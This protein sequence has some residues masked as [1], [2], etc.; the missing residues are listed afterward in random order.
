[1]SGFLQ[2]IWTGRANRRYL[3]IGFAVS[4]LFWILF[5]LLYPNTFMVIDS[6][7]YV[8]AAFEND[9]VHVWPIGYSKF[10][11]VIGLVSH[12][13]NLVAVSQYC[14]LQTTLLVFYFAM[15]YLFQLGKIA[16]AALYVFVLLN[17]IYL[18]TSNF[19]MSDSLFMSISL[20]WL[21]NLLWIIYRPKPWMLLTQAVLLLLAFTIRQVAVI[22]PVIA[23][24][25][26]LF[27][28]QRSRLKVIGIALSCLPVAGFVI[29]SIHMNETRYGSEMFSP[30]QGW[31]AANNALY[32]YDHVP[33]LDKEPVPPRF[34]ELDNLVR[35]YC[36][37][38]HLPS[39]VRAST[40]ALGSFYIF[41]YPSPLLVYQYEKFGASSIVIN[42]NNFAK[43]GPLY[44]DYGSF[45]LR[46]YPF[47]Y[48]QYYVVPN[49]SLYIYPFPEVYLDDLGS[50]SVRKDTL[51]TITEKWFGQISTSAPASS[52]RLRRTI[53]GHYQYLFS[54]IH[55]TYVI[56]FLAFFLFGGF[57]R[58]G[59]PRARLLLLLAVLWVAQF[60]FTA[61]SV[62]SVFRYQMFNTALEFA[63]LA[64]FIEF[65]FATDS[66]QKVGHHNSLR[67][68]SDELR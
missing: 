35:A 5:K 52:V 2:F 54:F 43:L 1:M 50:F 23:C 17:P 12:S 25:A 8:M 40:R 61:V 44:A 29:Y 32:A 31:Y 42:P 7:Y 45:I 16:S 51:G 46:K 15:R 36:Q 59:Q 41:V 18:Y 47:T 21:T 26:I 30:F 33:P 65:L 28:W 11:Q 48:F 4:M 10:L 3:A 63:L 68:D 37:S 66:N 9:P 62:V 19:I 24:L 53:F 20:L 49:I 22:Y 60:G 67:I 14:F 27:S 6:Y 57:K 58:I 55:I 34:Q 38:P 39:D 64:F 13:A 56:G